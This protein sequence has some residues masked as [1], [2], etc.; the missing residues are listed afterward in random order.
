LTL[1]PTPSLT[2]SHC[3]RHPH[4]SL[5]NSLSHCSLFPV[6]LLLVPT[7]SPD[8]GAGQ[9]PPPHEPIPLP[10]ELSS[11]PN[12]LL[13]PYLSP[14]LSPPYLH[15]P[16]ASWTMRRSCA[17]VLPAS[18]VKDASGSGR[19]RLRPTPGAAVERG[20]WR[21]RSQPLRIPDL[22]RSEATGLLPLK[23]VAAAVAGDEVGA[24]MGSQLPAPPRIGG[25]W[26]GLVRAAAPNPPGSSGFGESM[27]RCYFYF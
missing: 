16:S 13:L 8:A 17:P 20:A 7:A 14:K 21:S 3:R 1:I 24:A 6:S 25:R 5:S 11:P 27:G 26:R 15:Q 18:P 4:F 22:S 9:S 12:S 19:G 10:H 2:L 23:V